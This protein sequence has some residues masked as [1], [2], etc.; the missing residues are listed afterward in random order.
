MQH[1]YA[2]NDMLRKSKGHIFILLE[3]LK[4]ETLL[5]LQVLTKKV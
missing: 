1:F 3:N 2:V 4:N 5:D